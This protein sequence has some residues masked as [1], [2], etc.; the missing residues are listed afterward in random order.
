MTR[1]DYK[2]EIEER[3]A[4]GRPFTYGDL[5]LHYWP[6]IDVSRIADQ[7]IQRWR[8]KGW[9]SF[10]REGGTPVWSLT[11]AGRLAVSTGS[12]S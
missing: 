7:C 11:D 9:I 4:D 2:R 10:K 6:D 12:A 5:Y 8:R 1:D 3:M